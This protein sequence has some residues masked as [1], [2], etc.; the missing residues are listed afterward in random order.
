M[1]ENQI[2]FKG[3]DNVSYDNYY[4]VFAYILHFW[5]YN[6]VVTFYLCLLANS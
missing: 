1:S 4:K 3:D 2:I 6:S 5:F